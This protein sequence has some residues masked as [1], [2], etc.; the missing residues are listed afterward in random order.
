MSRQT[1]KMDAVNILSVGN[2][3]ASLDRAVAD[4]VTN[5]QILWL[6]HSQ[7][8]PAYEIQIDVGSG[9]D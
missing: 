5:L 4:W 6:T 8:A 3:P 2:N 1:G 7:K 9:L